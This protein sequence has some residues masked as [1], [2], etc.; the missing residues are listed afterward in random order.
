MSVSS[1]NKKRNIES[2]NN[3][4]RI[5]N[6]RTKLFKFYENDVEIVS[7][8]IIQYIL[9]T[10]SELN[11]IVSKE[12]SLGDTFI[13]KDNNI[14]K[15]LAI[16]LKT[17]VVSECYC[18][19]H[20]NLQYKGMLLM[21]LDIKEYLF[22]KIKDGY[23]IT[24]KMLRKNIRNIFILPF[25]NLKQSSTKIKFRENQLKSFKIE[26]NELNSALLSYFKNGLVIKQ[27][28]VKW[29]LLF[30]HPKHYTFNTN[31]QKFIYYISL[32]KIQVFHVYNV[33]SMDL[34]IQI[35]GSMIAI[36]FMSGSHTVSFYNNAKEK[37]KFTKYSFDVLCVHNKDYFNIKL[38]IPI[39]ALIQKGL[40]NEENISK[41]LNYNDFIKYELDI[42]DQDFI[43]NLDQLCKKHNCY[44]TPSIKTIESIILPGN[45]YMQMDQFIEETYY[46]INMYTQTEINYTYTNL[47]TKYCNDITENKNLD[48][49]IEESEKIKG[50]PRKCPKCKYIDKGTKGKMGRH[51][52]THHP[53][54]VKNYIL[55]ANQFTTTNTIRYKCSA[56]ETKF[57]SLD[58][59]K[60]HIK[61]LKCGGN[62]LNL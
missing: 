55:R 29:N 38:F 24:D 47:V 33:C 6:K 2:L 25:S 19:P 59:I 14:E 13:I 5:N 4:E 22:N 60:S 53:E 20:G 43:L 49:D 50:W 34:Y 30:E 15:A 57:T 8:K 39:S 12:C 27:D 28:L 44:K 1:I 26:Y 61:K 58:H 31:M 17:S 45:N 52:K 36:K 7:F 21:G 42:T 18:F 11:I 40:I 62:I 3:I 37:N 46:L 56:C 9:K 54:I 10:S 32:F 41:S 48:V 16:Q 23:E 35:N 51:I